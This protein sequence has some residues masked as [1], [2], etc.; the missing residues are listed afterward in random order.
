MI[1]ISN[2]I[3]TLMGIEEEAVDKDD[4]E[5]EDVLTWT[6]YKT[7]WSVSPLSAIDLYLFLPNLNYIDLMEEAREKHMKIVNMQEDEDAQQLH[8][9]IP[10]LTHHHLLDDGMEWSIILVGTYI[11]NN[12]RQDNIN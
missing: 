8:I 12:A 10:L 3:R 11:H 6:R 5:F 2:C 7:L 9:S 4:G 1:I